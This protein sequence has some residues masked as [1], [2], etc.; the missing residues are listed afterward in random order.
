MRKR[1]RVSKNRKR[2]EKYEKD[3]RGNTQSRHKAFWER[4]AG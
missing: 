2:R 1:E 4:L 3:V